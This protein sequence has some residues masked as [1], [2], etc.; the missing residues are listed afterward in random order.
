MLFYR[1]LLCFLAPALLI[2]AARAG[3]LSQRLGGGDREPAP[4]VWLHAAS[5]GEAM[6]ARPLIEAMLAKAPDLTITVTCNTT[7][8]RDLVAGWGLPGVAARLAPLDFR[9]ALRRFMANLRPQ[10][11]IVIENELWPNRLTMMQAAGK[12]VIVASARM[13]QRS[14]RGWARR[15][16]MAERIMSAITLLSA[17]DT[18]SQRRFAQLGLTPDRIA[19]VVNLKLTQDI[20]AP[21]ADTLARLRPLLPRAATVLA[22]S[23]HEGED[24]IILSAF[25]RARHDRP[26]LRLILAPRHPRRGDDL[27]TM[28]TEGGLGCSRQSAGQMPD[29]PVHLADTMGEMPLWYALAGVTFVG[30]SLVPRGGHTPFEPAAYD[31]A[32]VHGPHLDNFADAYAAL[33]QAGASLLVRDA[34]DLA[35][36]LRDPARTDPLPDRAR[37]VIDPMRGT[38]ALGDLADRILNVIHS[39]DN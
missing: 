38:E 9:W 13:S 29:Q 7:T 17:Q 37:A 6:A 31:S 24:E 8:G 14:A 33:Q 4:T 21:P 27:A 32:I 25:V 23:T 39:A 3:G 30:G 11:L 26:E 10:A 12:P 20:P 34:V 19:P 1:L 28:I 18:A 22:A 36:I 2:R 16:A 5:N 15:P 35:D